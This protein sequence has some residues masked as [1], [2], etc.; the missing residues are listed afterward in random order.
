MLSVQSS[1]H[2]VFDTKWPFS[3]LHVLKKKQLERY[4]WKCYTKCDTRIEH[5]TK[6]VPEV[7]QQVTD[8][9]YG[10][11]YEGYKLSNSFKSVPQ[12]PDQISQ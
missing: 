8:T 1:P 12:L 3:V 11:F 10:I 5:P 7:F 2:S 4:F 6:R 9:I